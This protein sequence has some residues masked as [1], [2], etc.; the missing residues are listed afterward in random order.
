[1]KLLEQLGIKKSMISPRV[2]VRVVKEELTE[3]F[4]E[5][6]TEFWSELMGI[7]TDRFRKP[8]I[9]IKLKAGRSE[10]GTVSIRINS[11]IVGTLF[12]FWTDSIL[13]DQCSLQ[14]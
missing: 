3:G 7:P 2:Q 4:S 13:R 1:M 12:N 5:R 11:G 6:L 10:H 8:S 9:R 14:S